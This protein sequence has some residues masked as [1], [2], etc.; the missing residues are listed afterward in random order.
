VRRALITGAGGFIGRHL[1][2]RLSSLGFD[3]GGIGLGDWPTTAGGG[4]GFRSMVSGRVGT[5]T[6]QELGALSGT[7]DAIFHLAGGSSVGAALADPLEDFDRSVSST[8]ILLDWVRQRAPGARVVLA[9]S[10]AVYGDAHDAPISESGVVRPYSPYGHHKRLSEMLCESYV[11]SFGLHCTAVRLFSVYG[12]G[13]QKQILWDLCRKLRKD[14]TSLELGGTGREV[15]DWLHV[16]D[17]C[18]FLI[19][20]LDEPSSYAARN[21]GTGNG[22]SVAE[23]ARLVATAWG[24]D[25]RLAFSGSTRT[26]DPRFLVADPA[27]LRTIA[28]HPLR[29]FTAGIDEYVEWYKSRLAGDPS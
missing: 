21:A 3:V 8:A 7:P 2:R 14:R 11:E 27:C 12:P 20:A 9:S 29:E 17:A 25:P 5:E 26:G 22:T 24:A 23:A 6:L 15:R 4:W 1:A 19:A 13:L 18:A 10:A 16:D 28:P